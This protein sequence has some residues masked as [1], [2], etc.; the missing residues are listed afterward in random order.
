MWLMG[1]PG[2]KQIEL[3]WAPPV[4]PATSASRSSWPCMLPD[5]KAQVDDVVWQDDVSAAQDAGRGV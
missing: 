1:Q 5:G 4:P 3:L 2:G